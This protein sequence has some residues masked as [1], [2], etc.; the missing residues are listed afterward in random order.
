M[1][2]LL[3]FRET[4][5]KILDLNNEKME[6]FTKSVKNQLENMEQGMKTYI[7]SMIETDKKNIKAEFEGIETKMGAVKME[8]HRYA[9]DLKNSATELKAE[10]DEIV[11]IK[12]EVVDKV[13]SSSKYVDEIN[14]NTLDK[15]YKLNSD[16]DQI[17]SKFN[18]IAEFVKVIKSLT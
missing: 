5:K 10:K 4:T 14:N 1:N 17:R 15:F 6:N 7:K 3:T 13:E 11:K 2:T 8:N 16:Y 12:N 18:E 9:I